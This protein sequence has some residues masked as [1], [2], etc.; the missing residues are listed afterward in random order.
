M[1]LALRRPMMTMGTAGVLL[2]RFYAQRS[3]SRSDRLVSTCALLPT[4]VHH[5]GTARLHGKLTQCLCQV[6]ATA[7]FFLA[8]KME[9]TPRSLQRI[10]ESMHRCYCKE[11]QTMPDAIADA[12]WNNTVSKNWVAMHLPVLSGMPD[13]GCIRRHTKKTSRLRF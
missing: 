2:H 6:A 9:D 5:V 13:K 11:F 8:G 10:S 4:A 3:L 7:C 1:A 12:R